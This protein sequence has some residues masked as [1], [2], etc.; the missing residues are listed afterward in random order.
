[1][2]WKNLKGSKLPEVLSNPQKKRVYDESGEAG[3]KRKNF[4]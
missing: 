2:P 1:M 4:N 3:L